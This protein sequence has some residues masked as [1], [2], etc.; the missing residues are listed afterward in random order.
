MALEYCFSQWTEPTWLRCLPKANLAVGLMIGGVLYVLCREKDFTTWRI[1]KGCL[2]QLPKTYAVESNNSSH[3]NKVARSVETRRFEYSCITPSLSA[4][5][6]SNLWSQASFSCQL[7]QIQKKVR[8]EVDYKEENE[9]SGMSISMC[10]SSDY[11]LEY[12]RKFPPPDEYRPIKEH[13]I[14][15]LPLCAELTKEEKQAR[16]FVHKEREE[17]RR[18]AYSIAAQCHRDDDKVREAAVLRGLDAAIQLSVVQMYEELYISCQQFRPFARR[19]QDGI[20]IDVGPNGKLPA[21]LADIVLMLADESNVYRGLEDRCVAWIGNH[22][23][24]ARSRAI[25]AVLQSQRTHPPETLREISITH[26]H[27]SRC[28]GEI[29]AISDATV[30]S[31]I[32]H[33]VQKS[34]PDCESNEGK[35]SRRF[36]KVLDTFL[37]P[38]LT[39]S[40][41]RAPKMPAFTHH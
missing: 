22:R 6:T 18:T 31:A 37:L 29:I 5:E 39:N 16:W 35:D 26:S 11:R 14:D 12:A 24:F 7:Q 36:H 23:R 2:D 34:P 8:F 19:K 1:N 30:S 3:D 13:I 9:A 38:R 15:W 21:E 4:V 40:S 25:Q 28:F 33:A 41:C 10:N 32:R 27:S 17:I 20:R